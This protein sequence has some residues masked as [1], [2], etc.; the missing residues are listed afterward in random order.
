M[1]SFE[2]PS[3]TINLNYI[4]DSV[5]SDLIRILEETNLEKYLIVDDEIIHILGLVAPQSFL[6]EHQVKSL[7]PLS[8]NP[9]SLKDDEIELVY[10][11]RPKIELM[12]FIS[13]HINYFQNSLKIHPKIRIYLTPR[14]TLICEKIFDELDLI[15]NNLSI[16]EF[17]LDLIP[18][19]SDII[20]MELNTCFRNCFLEGDYSSLY[21]IARS[22]MKIQSFYGLIPNIKSKGNLSCIVSGMIKEMNKST[23]KLLNE[24]PQFQTLILIDRNIDLITPM[25]LPLTYEGLIDELFEIQCGKIIKK[26]QT[27]LLN[28]TDN[29]YSEI[30]DLNQIYLGQFLKKIATNIELEIEEKKNLKTVQQIKEFAN[31]LNRLQEDKNNLEVHINLVKEIKAHIQRKLFKTAVEMQQSMLLGD[32]SNDVLNYIENCINSKQHFLKIIRL[33]SLY[34][35]TIGFNNSSKQKYE[36]FKNEILQT[37]GYH[38]L[39][40]LRDLENSN[41]IGLNKSNNWSNIKKNF[42]LLEEDLDLENSI[43]NIHSVFSGFT[44]VALKLIESANEPWDKKKKFLDL[45]P[46]ETLEFN[47]NSVS[48]KQ[49]ILVYFIGGITAS[50]MNAIRYLN[51]KYKGIREYVV[52]TTKLINGDSFL[53]NLFE[54]NELN[55][56]NKKDEEKEINK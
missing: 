36:Y 48:E 37:Y 34:C 42:K 49:N 6:Q 55:G 23:F 5:I 17:P 3:T 28:S 22:I 32:N 31:K 33:F 52:I 39:I 43:Y 53:N 2:F 15:N 4:R 51:K 9:I 18:F 40:E 1:T 20:S 30:R 10:L 29:V 13:I 50:E 46:G 35:L 12:N 44:P 56:E 26:D 11:C 54:K 45:L 47:Q 16:S 27:I 25:L 38:K 21:F 8:K 24:T 19:D 14:K 41:L 7:F